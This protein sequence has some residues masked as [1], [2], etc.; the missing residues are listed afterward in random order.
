M[1]LVAQ[2]LLNVNRAEHTSAWSLEQV[3]QA[4]GH[5]DETPPPPPPTVE[6]LHDRFSLLADVFRRNGDADGS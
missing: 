1:A 5:P 3:M 4:L 6:Q 2:I